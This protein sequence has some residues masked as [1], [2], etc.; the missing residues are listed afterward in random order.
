M[1]TNIFSVVWMKKI[2]Q[3]E[4]VVA[5]DYILQINKTQMHFTNTYLPLFFWP[6]FIY[7]IHA[8]M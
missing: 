7:I 4:C 5:F 1:K 3:V 8:I 2:A 6:V